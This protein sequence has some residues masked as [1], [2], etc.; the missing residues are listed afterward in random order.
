MTVVKQNE[1]LLILSKQGREFDRRATVTS[2]IR[3]GST[4]RKIK[5]DRIFYIMDIKFDIHKI[6]NSEGEGGERKYIV[7]QQQPPM[8][9]TEMEKEIEKACSLTQGDVR[10]VLT[11]LRSLIVRQLSLG[12]RFYLPGVGWL[13]LTAGLDKAAQE[14][15]HKITGKDVYLRGI[16]F[17]EDR[18]LLEEIARNVNFAKS[19]YT[20]LSVNYTEEELWAKIRDFLSSHDFLTRKNMR[21]EFGLSEFKANQWL[22]RFVVAGKLRQEGTKHMSIYIVSHK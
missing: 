18:K 1:S 10:A 6:N 21:D 5:G 20:S 16:Q 17:R 9:E 2:I 4:S 15:G 22:K 8:T 11:E 13:S 3:L 19:K 7:L 12:S 14:K